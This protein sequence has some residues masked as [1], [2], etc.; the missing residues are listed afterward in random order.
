MTIYT[1]EKLKQKT[2]IFFNVKVIA[3]EVLFQIVCETLNHCWTAILAIFGQLL[4]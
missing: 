4:T 3:R 2:Q 1:T